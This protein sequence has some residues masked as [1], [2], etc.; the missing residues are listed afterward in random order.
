VVTRYDR[1]KRPDG[2]I[3]RLH[4]EDFCQALGILPEQKY[5]AEG[6]ASLVDCF[7]IL[8]RYSVRPA[9]DQ[10]ALLGW[11]IFNFPIGNAD[12]HAKNLS[13]MITAPGPRLAPFYDLLS[14][15]VYPHLTEKLAMKIGGENRVGWLQ[16]RHWERFADDIELKRRYVRDRVRNM[17]LRIPP[18]AR[19]L[20]ESVA[21]NMQ[22]PK[23]V[24]QVVDLIQKQASR[25]G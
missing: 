21:E 10:G 9:G 12:A 23:I 6:G 24:N 7:S 2:T 5:E 17:A 13:L 11:V 8:K 20:S 18:I 22:G 25:W 1:E 15:Q 14:T 3:Q 4:Q 19:T 16:W